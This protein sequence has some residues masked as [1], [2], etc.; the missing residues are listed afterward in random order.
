MNRIADNFRNHNFWKRMNYDSEFYSNGI[1]SAPDLIEKTNLPLSHMYILSLNIV[2]W[3]IT[4]H[5]K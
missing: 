3:E 4:K 5:R 1:I 2:G